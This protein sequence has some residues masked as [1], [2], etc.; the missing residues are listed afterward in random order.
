MA[1]VANLVRF[2]GLLMRIA[3]GAGWPWSVAIP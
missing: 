1:S 2:D 3:S